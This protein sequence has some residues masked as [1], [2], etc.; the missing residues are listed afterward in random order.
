MV[1]VVSSRS[2]T[3]V[4]SQN[5]VYYELSV[6]ML[7]NGVVTSADGFINCH[8][9]CS[10]SYLANTGVTLNASPAQGWTF[11]GWSGACNGTG[12]C[13]LLM[14]QDYLMP[15]AEAANGLPCDPSYIRRCAAWLSAS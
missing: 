3:A 4:F 6:S 7:G 10:H 11:S 9:T 5:P 2:V 1:A 13:N 15:S 14:T 12:P 8:G